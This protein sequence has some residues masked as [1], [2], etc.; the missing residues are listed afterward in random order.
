[1]CA[2]LPVGSHQEVLSTWSPSSIKTPMPHVCDSRWPPRWV[3]FPTWL[4]SSPAH[5]SPT[6]AS[7]DCGF[8]RK[9]AEVTEQ[10]HVT[11]GGG[12]TLHHERTLSCALWLLVEM[13]PPV[14][15]G[16]PKYIIRTGRLKFE[17]KGRIGEEWETAPWF[18]IKGW[19]YHFHLMFIHMVKLLC[20]ALAIEIFPFL[21]LSLKKQNQKHVH[22][23]LKFI[24][25][26]NPMPTKL[27]K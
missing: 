20:G 14:R 5:G 18:R 24:L 7:S 13:L 9:Q 15:W 16:T 3:N 2:H 19:P 22:L 1:M 10:C 12:E 21:N 27:L 8:P 4:T 6:G 26:I 17:W 25:A 23:S 11:M